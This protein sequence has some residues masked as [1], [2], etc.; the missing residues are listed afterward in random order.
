[1]LSTSETL[2][3][4]WWLVLLEG[5][6]AII[7]GFLLLISPIRTTVWLVQI[8]GFYWLIV[9]ILAIV[10]IFLDHSL[11][12]WK[13]FSGILGILAGLIVIRN[14]WWSTVLVV[15]LLVI[16]LA[17][18]ALIQGV[19]KLFHS[20]NGGGFG[21][22]VLGLLNI[23]IGVVLL[24]NTLIAASIL[25][26]VVGILAIIGGIAAI[27]GAFRMHGHAASPTMQQSPS[28]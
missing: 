13:L 19:I 23:I 9:G 3:F 24:F 27:I 14:P 18:Q 17:V 21:A 16:V 11:W 8:M 15:S 2:G 26:F 20:F 28:M 1:M 10:N 22:F 7:V 25:P 5:I 12:G 6:A 4:P